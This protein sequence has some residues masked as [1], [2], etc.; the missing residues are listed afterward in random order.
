MTTINYYY[1]SVSSHVYRTVYVLV[2]SQLECCY[3]D[4]VLDGNII[5]RMFINI[6]WK[7]IKRTPRCIIA[8]WYEAK[9]NYFL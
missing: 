4:T 9:R 8:L 6:F 7:L 5:I 2:L 1:L 3:G